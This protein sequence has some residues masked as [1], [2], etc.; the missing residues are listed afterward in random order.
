MSCSSDTPDSPESNGDVSS[1]VKLEELIVGEWC[2]YGGAPLGIISHSDS[3]I[4]DKTL[5]FGVQH[6]LV[7]TATGFIKGNVPH[8]ASVSE[9]GSWKILNGLLI[10]MDWNGHEIARLNAAVNNNILT[11]SDDKGNHAIYRNADKVFSNLSYEILG[12]WYEFTDG[13]KSPFY[14][15]E[16]NGICTHTSYMWNHGHDSPIPGKSRFK[17]SL[18]GNV[19]TMTTLPVE[20]K[21]SYMT[22][23]CCNSEYLILDDKI[24]KRHEWGYS[25]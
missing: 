15:F 16:D 1:V 24:L 5:N 18:K 7:E 17:W 19:L 20:Y 4:V 2:F 8:I 13:T 9:N 11:L 6:G 22:V 14:G 21:T 25:I 3:E 12:N 23:K 10:L